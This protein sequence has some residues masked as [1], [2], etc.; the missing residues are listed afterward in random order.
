MQLRLVD[1]Y[2]NMDVQF[3]SKDQ[4]TVESEIFRGVF[5]DSDGDADF[6]FECDDILEDIADRRKN[7]YLQFSFYKG[8]DF[9]SFSGKIDQ[10]RKWNGIRA[11]KVAMLSGIEKSSRRVAHRIEVSIPIEIAFGEMA[12][13]YQ[14]TTYDISNN[15]IGLMSNDEIKSKDM[16]DLTFNLLENDFSFKAKMIR[17]GLNYKSR[18]YRYDYVFVFEEENDKEE[19]QKLVLTMFNYRMSFLR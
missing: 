6:Y 16:V 9:F 12:K 13:V 18:H 7:N 5:L 8:S 14:G 4:K 19:I 2:T 10:E 1:R 17:G 15:A 3:V 11:I